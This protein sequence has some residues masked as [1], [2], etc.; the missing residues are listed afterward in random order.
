MAG[1][2]VPVKRWAKRVLWG[3]GVLLVVGL[4][5]AAWYLAKA[6]PIGTG[7]AAKYICSSV[8]I[9][10]RDAQVVFRED[11]APVAN[12]FS[13]IIKVRVDSVHKTVTAHIF[14][15]FASKA[16]YREGCGCTLLRHTTEEALRGQK[17]L[18]HFAVGTPLIS[19][20]SPWPL[21]NQGPTDPLPAGVDAKKLK[22]AVDTA[23]LETGYGNPRYTRAVVVVYDGRLIAE[24]YAAGID[25]NTPLL[26]WSMAKSVTNALVGILVR[27]GKLD[28]RSPA[29]VS[30]WRQVG[31]PRQ[32]ITLDQLLRMSSGLS[33]KEKYGPLSDATDMLYGAYDFG[34]FAASKPLEAGPDSKWNYSSGTANIIARIVRQAIEKDNQDSYEFIRRELLD[35]IGM[36]SFVLEPDPAGTFAGSSY[37]F[38]SARDWARF[39][40][41]Y[42][43]DGVWQDERILPE[44]WVR[45][46]RTPTPKSPRG[47]YGALFWLNAGSASDPS[48][49]RWPRLPTDTFA[50]QGY[51]GQIV[52]IIPSR[53][54]VLVRLGNTA[55]LKTWNLQSFAAEILEGIPE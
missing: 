32:A 39:G 26:G 49:R 27:K 22:R 23:F 10:K 12:P 16:I 3:L 43:Q 8:F 53:K 37:I 33:F 34:A 40:L 44:G 51:Q 54:L 18:T 36:E 14:G 5:G 48:D 47:E 45:Y 38:A 24:R 31:D 19:P 55:D 50:A 9:S 29:P 7:Y 11:V 1:K 28:L 46:S 35:K 13:R 2:E 52:L 42:L 25:Q 21:G 4:V 20:D 30:E 17:F 6:L 41:L 15:F